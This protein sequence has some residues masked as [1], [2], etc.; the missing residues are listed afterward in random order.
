VDEQRTGLGKEAISTSSYS[1]SACIFT[2][3][4]EVLINAVHLRPALW[5]QRDKNY[6]N[7]DLNL[8]NPSV[9]YMGCTAQLNSRLCILYIYSTNIGTEHFKH[10]ALSVFFSSKCRLFHNGTFF[11]SCII[12][13]SRTGCAKIKKQNSVSKRLTASDTPRL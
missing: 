13:I 10:A 7:R 9:P 11:G 8:L 12:Q 6:Q 5:E 4:C 1:L 3:D 2:M